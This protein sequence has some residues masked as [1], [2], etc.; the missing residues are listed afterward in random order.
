MPLV[1]G[2]VIVTLNLRPIDAAKLL[3]L[4]RRGDLTPLQVEDVSLAT[5]KG[6]PLPDAIAALMKQVDTPF[7]VRQLGYI[8]L[9]N[10]DEGYGIIERDGGGFLVFDLDKVSLLLHEGDRVE[11]NEKGTPLPRQTNPEH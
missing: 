9:V 8:V 5:G 4:A 10:R 3:I 11:A 2:S 1:L 6:L 7:G